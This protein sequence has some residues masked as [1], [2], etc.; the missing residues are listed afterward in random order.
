[1]KSEFPEYY[2]D[3]QHLKVFT[4][5]SVNW[6]LPLGHVVI[7]SHSPSRK[8]DWVEGEEERGR[9]YLAQKRRCL[10]GNMYYNNTTILLKIISLMP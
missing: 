10:I 3:V 5:F 1:M 9:A 2:I 8:G 7:S 4:C 6:I